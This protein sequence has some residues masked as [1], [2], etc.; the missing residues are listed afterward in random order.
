MTFNPPRS[1]LEYPVNQELPV[2]I[3]RST[4]SPTASDS[5]QFRVRDFWI[6]STL[7]T[8]YSLVDKTST[9]AV[10]INL[11][12]GSSGDVTEIGSDS[13]T[14]FP[15]AGNITIAGGTGI[16]TSGAGD[17]IT[18]NL[19]IPVTV[20]RGGTG[21]T[22]L[23]DGGILLGSGAGAVTVTAQPTDGQLL[24]GSSGLDPVL[25]TLIAGSGVTV[26]N[27]AGSITISSTGG[28]VFNWNEV[29][30]TSDTFVANNG[31]VTNNAG[32][33]TITLPA[34]CVFGESFAIMGKGAGGWKVAQLASQTI[35]F[36]NNDTTTGVAGSLA[37]TGQ[38]DVVEFLCTAANTDFTVRS[39]VGT[40]TV[41]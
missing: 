3:F 19:D 10:W 7:R 17:T 14:A 15:S 20:P 23:T 6:D 33:V 28:S 5:R 27:G 36:A 24:T 38:F 11:G 26:V 22:S 31:F 37:S 12:V 30:G 34:T 40:I 29:V 4:R 1:P 8:I 13:G 16:N 39:P 21:L 41:A 35:H 25:N 9:G 18:V 32:L 2:R